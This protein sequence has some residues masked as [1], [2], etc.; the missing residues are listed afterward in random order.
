MHRHRQE[1]RRQDHQLDGSCHGRG[2]QVAQ[3]LAA[4]EPGPDGQQRQRRAGQRAADPDGIHAHQQVHG[5]IQ[6]KAQTHAAQQR[7]ILAALSI[8][9]EGVIGAQRQLEDQHAHGQQANVHQQ[10]EKLDI[11]HE[12]V[13]KKDDKIAAED[14]RHIHQQHDQ[15]AIAGHI[16]TPSS[17][18]VINNQPIFYYSSNCAESQTDTGIFPRR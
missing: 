7:Q 4:L 18:I 11:L 15:S 13:G 16:G 10:V 3:R 9:P 14:Q 17:P 2:A 12:Q 8:A 6:G 1:Q 5:G